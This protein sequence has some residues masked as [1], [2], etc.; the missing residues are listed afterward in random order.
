MQARLVDGLECCVWYARVPSRANIADF[1]SRDVQQCSLP[2]HLVVPVKYNVPH[3]VEDLASEALLGAKRVQHLSLSQY[4]SESS[5]SAAVKGERELRYAGS[6]LASQRW[7]LHFATGR[8]VARGA[9]TVTELRPP[10]ALETEKRGP[11]LGSA[12]LCC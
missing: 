2:E 9:R 4:S 10:F 6:R 1:P 12:R 5:G 3:V 8:C 7:R 11:L